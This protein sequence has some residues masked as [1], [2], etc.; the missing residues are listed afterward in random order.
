MAGRMSRSSPESLGPEHDLGSVHARFARAVLLIYLGTGAVAV[1]LLIGVLVTDLTYQQDAVR[2]TLLLETQVRAHYLGQHLSL[3]VGELTRLGLRS[4]VDLLDQNI[5]PER[6]LLRLAHE[7]S[8]F[9]NVGVAVVGPDGTILWSEPRQFLTVGASLAGEAWY[10]T[11]LRART[12]VVVPVQPEREKDSLLY[13]VSPI[14]RGGGFAGMLLGGVDLAREATLG[15]EFHPGAHALD[16]LATRQGTVIFPPK[17]PT[18]SSTPDWSRV[19]AGG[20]GEAFI[21]DVS[22]GEVGEAAEGSREPAGK[23]KLTVVAGAPVSGT[24]FLLLSLADSDRLFG[25]SRARMRTR[26]AVGLA[27]ALVP[28]LLL[29]LLLR[30]SFRVFRQSEERALVNERLRMLGEA[31]HLIAHEVKNSLNGLRVGLEMIL[32]GDRPYSGSRQGAA[33]VGLRAEVE[34]LSNFATEL[35]SFSKGVTP[36]PVSMDLSEFGHKVADL[37]RTRA[38]SLG[39]ALDVA[40]PASRV[41]VRADPSLVHTVIANL[42]GNAL[43]ALAGAPVEVPRVRVSLDAA[44]PRA[45]LRVRDNGPG[46]S[47]QIIS[48]LFEPFVTGKPSGVGIGLALSRKIARAHGGDLVLEAAGPGASFLFTLPLENS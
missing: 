1:A 45:C 36:R 9:F 42:V 11:V 7:K 17:P 18:F 3:L 38:E 15:S 28:L 31:V 19:M 20:H 12:A 5:E 40:V 10:Q 16:V 14:L 26:L 2:E 6:S 41:A 35:L 13:V 24:D 39:I 43:D 46:V 34:R 37:A 25:A 33:A 29:V 48:R 44:G 4:E 47:P 22:L 30:R 8:S 23:G 32:Q 21:T 27:L